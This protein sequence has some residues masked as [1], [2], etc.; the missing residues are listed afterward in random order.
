MNSCVWI[1]PNTINN[2][3]QDTWGILNT[4]A[5]NSGCIIQELFPVSG[6]RVYTRSFYNGRWY[7]WL[8]ITYEA[9]STTRMDYGTSGTAVHDTT[10]K[11][12]GGNKY[13]QFLIRASASNYVSIWI[14]N[15][16]VYAGLILTNVDCFGSTQW[17]YV[18][19]GA[20]ISVTPGTGST[21]YDYYFYVANTV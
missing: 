1:T 14:G 17:F 10:Y 18:P 6:S 8:G 7:Q 16:Q 5:A 9:S 21:V 13:V 2:P 19:K 12:S 11:A 15:I 20:T 3:C 4:W